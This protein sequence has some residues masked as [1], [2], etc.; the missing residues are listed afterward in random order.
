M[1]FYFDDGK[2]KKRA[3]G[4]RDRLILYENAKKRCQ[5]P[6]CNKEIEFVEMQIGHKKAWSKGGKTTFSNCVCLCYACNRKQGC[7][8]WA[9]FLKKQSFSGN[10][11]KVV[12]DKISTVTPIIEVKPDSRAIPVTPINE[13]NA[14]LKSALETLSI[15]QLKSLAKAHHIAVKG[16]VEMYV[17]G[18]DKKIPP[19]KRQYISKLKGIVTQ[20]EIDSL[21]K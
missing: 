18:P 16:K 8:S 20:E 11:E 13:K 15:S 19:T 2:D 7:D 3:M 1:Q 10:K 4:I 14:D 9:V 17:F 5:N 12:N 6:Y 21:P